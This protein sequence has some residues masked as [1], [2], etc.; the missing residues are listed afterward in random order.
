MAFWNFKK[1]SSKQ[2]PVEYGSFGE[3]SR[4]ALDLLELKPVEIYRAGNKEGDQWE[5]FRMLSKIN[6]SHRLSI[7]SS[8]TTDVKLNR[9]VGC[10]VGMAVAD[11]L[12]A[13][14]EF[15]PVANGDG[16]NDSR[17][18]FSLNTME[19]SCPSNKFRLKPGQWTDDASM[20]FCIADS[21]LANKGEYDGSD[22]RIRFH[23][24]WNFG[25]C[26]AFINDVSRSGSVGLGGNI[27]MSL[28]SCRAGVIPSPTFER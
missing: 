2:E 20:G 16:E 18:F 21:Y 8:V 9:A 26:N 5:K 11:A 25:Y 27:A 4:A 23:L 28:D 14:L 19:Y 22:I 17:H 1:A 10:M 3:A 7:L 12:G 24:W 6:L 15:L 13:P